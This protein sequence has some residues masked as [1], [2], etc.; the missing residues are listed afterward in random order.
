MFSRLDLPR[1]RYFWLYFHPL[2][3]T[4]GKRRLRLG[5][6]APYSQAVCPIGSCIDR[7]DFVIIASV[8]VR[9]GR[10]LFLLSPGNS[11]VR[12][13]SS[14]LSIAHVETAICLPFD[15][16]HRSGRDSFWSAEGLGRPLLPETVIL[17]L[18][19]RDSSVQHR[20]PGFRDLLGLTDASESLVWPSLLFLRRRLP[21]LCSPL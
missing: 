18:T 17:N 11:T 5:Y 15:N 19:I 4:S 1:G 3:R 16:P 20:R 9:A 14:C 6:F 7:S 21:S 13:I 2:Q 10:S 8:I 12:L